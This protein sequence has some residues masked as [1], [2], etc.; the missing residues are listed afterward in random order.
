M[1]QSRP[2]LVKTLVLM[3]GAF[4]ALLPPMKPGEGG[5]SL[6]AVVKAVAARFKQGDIDGGLEVWVDRDTPGVWQRRSEAD[7]Q[8]SRDNAWTLISPA[9]PGEVTC[10]DVAGLTMPVLLMQGEKTTRRSA[11]IV[12]ETRKCLPSAGHIMIPEAGH[13]MQRMNLAGFRAAL[14]SF[15]KK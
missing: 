1:A 13:A 4:N 5:I 9:G 14:F 12:E 7:R 10:P 11:R 6:P 8:V 3:E 15:L 2:E